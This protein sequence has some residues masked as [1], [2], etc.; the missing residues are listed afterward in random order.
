MLK[1]YVLNLTYLGDNFSGFQFQPEQRTIQGT[2]EDLLSKIFDTTIKIAYPSRTDSG[3]HAIEYFLNF[4]VKT[5]YTEK[6]IFK[7]LNTQLPWDIRIKSVHI[8]PNNFSTQK[9]EKKTYLYKILCSE[10]YDPL[11]YQ[12]VWWYRKDIDLNRMQEI[13]SRFVGTHDFK[14]FMASGS[15]VKTTIRTVIDF[16]M[17]KIDDEIHL[18]IT[19]NGFLRNMVRNIV[20]TV[21]DYAR[22]RFSKEDIDNIFTSLDREKAGICAPPYGLYLYKLYYKNL[23]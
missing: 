14:A 15:F 10:F 17:E 21:L 1:N 20:G 19:A 18:Y 16:K 12:K 13:L 6:Q 23:K 22:G 8:L 3:V 5:N 11:R 2:I 4:K 7:M 9:P